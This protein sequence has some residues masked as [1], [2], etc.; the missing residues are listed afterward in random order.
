[1]SRKDSNLEAQTRRDSYR[2]SRR[3]LSYSPVYF[4]VNRVRLLKGI[5]DRV[6]SKRDE[7]MDAAVSIPPSLDL[8]FR[9][10]QQRQPH[11]LGRRPRDID[12]LRK[13]LTELFVIQA[14]NL[15]TGAK[16]SCQATKFV[17]VILGFC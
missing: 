16:L 1:M 11:M 17:D 4:D 7:F 15:A 12:R 14:N 2:R 3:F 13:L 5:P 6:S 9:R 10:F 8:S